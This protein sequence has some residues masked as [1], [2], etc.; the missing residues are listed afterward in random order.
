MLQKEDEAVALK[1]E[2]EQQQQKARSWASRESEKDTEISQLNVELQGLHARQLTSMSEEKE[3]LVVELAE[4]S[5]A[6]EEVQ[7]KLVSMQTEHVALSERLVRQTEHTS[8]QLVQAEEANSLKEFKFNQIIEDSSARLNLSKGCLLSLLYRSSVMLLCAR[9]VA[10]WKWSKT[11]DICCNKTMQIAV[12]ALEAE[13]EALE[14]LSKLT[15]AT[16]LA[17]VRLCERF[18]IRTSIR[19]LVRM[20]QRNVVDFEP[21]ITNVELFEQNVQIFEQTI[22]EQ[23]VLSLGMLRCHVLK[24]YQLERTALWNWKRCAGSHQLAARSMCSSF[25]ISPTLTPMDSLLGE[26]HR[27]STDLVSL[28]SNAH[29]GPSIRQALIAVKMSSFQSENA[30][31]CQLYWWALRSSHWHRATAH[32]ASMFHQSHRYELMVFLSPW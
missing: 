32:L 24:Q 11:C 14:N 1:R 26:P 21:S 22:F 23:S 16:Q 28:P 25:C 31:R 15:S 19:Q 2:V 20:W 12:A 30:R 5:S 3:K 13:D 17:S 29:T 4:K 7:Q 18:L 8:L 10:T 9:L 27:V 6:Y